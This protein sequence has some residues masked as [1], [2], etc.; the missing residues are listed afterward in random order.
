MNPSTHNET[1]LDQIES[2]ISPV[3]LIILLLATF[4]GAAAAILVLPGWIPGMSASISGEQPKVFWYLSRASAIIAYF[5]L[6]ASMVLGVGITNKA[7]AIWPGLPSAIELHQFFTILGMIF[8]LFHG[9]ILAGDAYL[10]PTLGQIFTPFSM[11]QYRPISVGIGQ[12]AFYLWIVITISFYAR[13]II[14]KKGWRILHY[15]SYLTYIIALMHGLS[16]G[17]DTGLNWTRM[18]YGSTFIILLAM[19]VYRIVR[20]RALAAEKRKLPA[21]V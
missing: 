16:A 17:T 12:I 6:W 20:S 13:R 15:F 18:I 21:K 9:L 1:D 8:A 10:K 4:G 7:A 3:W 11:S 14:T 2:P 19:T 5:L